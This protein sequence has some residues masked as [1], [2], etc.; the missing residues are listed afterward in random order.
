MLKIAHIADVHWR[1]LSRHE[2]YRHVFSHFIDDCKKKGVDHIFVGGDIFHTKTTGISPEFID[3]LTWWLNDMSKVA[4]VHLTL[5]NHDGNLVNLSRQDA[6][7]PIVQALKNDRVRLYKKSG[8]Y[9]F[10]P[11]YN[12]CVFSLFD[13]EGWKNVRPIPGKVNI[14]CYHG[15]VCGSVSETGWNIDEGV[16]VEFFEGYDFAFL[17][18]IHKL[19]YLSY[20]NDKP[21]IAYP[22]TPLQQNYAEDID[23][24][25]LLWNVKSRDEWSVSFEKLPNPKP[26]VT[27]NWDGSIDNLQEN[28]KKHPVGTRF[29]IRSTDHISQKEVKQIDSLLADRFCA[30]EITYKS[31]FVLDKSSIKTETATLVKSD[32]R[33]ADVVLKLI[34][35]HHKNSTVTQEMWTKIG[36]RTKNALAVVSS[37]EETTRNSKWSLRHLSFDN[38]FTYGEGNSI[39]FDSLNGIVGI[40]GSNRIGKSSIVGT[41]MYSL[42]NTTDRGPMKNIHVCN[43]RKP[44]CSSRVILNHNGT[45]YI[46]ERQT[47][48]TENKRGV[49]NAST[50]LNFYRM[51]EDGEVEELNGEQRNDTEKSLRLLIG[52]SEDFLMTSLS[53][54]GEINQFI[55]QGSTR[56]RAILSK[57]LDLDVFDKMHDV[58]TKEAG[59]IKQQLKNYPDKNW[60]EIIENNKKELSRIN[61]DIE[62]ASAQLHDK[63]ITIAQLQSELHKHG[64]T[65]FVTKDQLDFQTKKVENLKASCE[66]CESYI[67]DLQQQVTALKEKIKTIH[68]VKEQNDVVA[69]RTK[70]KVYKSLEESLTTLRFSFEKE[71]DL[72]KRYQKSLKIL[73]EVPCGDEYPSCMFIKDAHA[74][75]E[76]V[77]DQHSLVV[78]SKQK[79]DQALQA[80]KD[81][82]S[83]GDLE[84]LEK[85]EKIIEMESKIELDISKKETEIAKLKSSCD[86]KSGELDIARQRL[87]LLEKAVKNAEN[88]EISTIK[89]QLEIFSNDIKNID[90][91]KLE[92][93]TKKGKLLSETESLSKEKSQRDLLLDELKLHDLMLSAFSKKGI[94]LVITRS[95]L[96]AINAEISKILQGIVEFSIE[97]ENE[98]ESDTTE[99]Y[100]NYGDSRRV[101]E[102]CSGMEKTIASLAVRVAMIN[103][104]SLPRPDI[105]I[106]D[107]GF[108]TLDDSS[109]EACNRLLISLK[110]HFKTIVVITHVDGIKDIV[111]TVLEISKNEKD[112][113]ITYGE[114]T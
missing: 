16:N 36:E 99:I 35:D 27:L 104:S 19:Q 71:E 62:A 82:K 111:D 31:D 56:R 26:Y 98:E 37:Q 109:V 55:M 113:K 30:T 21:W 54:Q 105:F 70:K 79:L 13:E 52:S 95:Q 93:A 20:R 78:L 25:Y 17:G 88:A 96:P 24:G 48:K 108:G 74:N 45:D 61:D 73:D 76:K 5:G 23:H 87:D 1:G 34:K 8:T 101:I 51:K 59:V 65:T 75:K 100:I 44:F 7:S 2:E 106:I 80:I 12:W 103:V 40:F 90:N 43:V 53:A 38:M 112:A 66:E 28:A 68:N 29:R 18:D 15:S 86:A 6:I 42:F 50:A 67:Q 10:S 63:Q 58:V 91:L 57:F 22:G 11:G 107:E 83:Q 85:L 46:V 72:L 102:L 92:A 47:T 110:R 114:T 77:H 39:N 89:K 64:S 49:V 97:L 33:S 84:K 94:P 41:I 81:L 69:L 60:N 3:Q 4:I 32:L 9:E 14:A